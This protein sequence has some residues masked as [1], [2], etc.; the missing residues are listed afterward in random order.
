MSENYWH[1]APGRPTADI[2][3]LVALSET[4]IQNPP[5]PAHDSKCMLSG[6]H[7]PTAALTSSSP[8][9]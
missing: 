5:S 4:I 7:N 8:P 1:P 2:T 3:I 9:R 6:L